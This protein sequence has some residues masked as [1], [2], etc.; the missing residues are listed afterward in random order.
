MR[1]VEQEVVLLGIGP[2]DEVY[3]SV[4]GAARDSGRELP[5]LRPGARRRGPVPGRLRGP[6]GERYSPQDVAEI[7]IAH[8]GLADERPGSWEGAN[9]LR[10][11]EGHGIVDTLADD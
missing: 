6:F 7:L 10:V 4:C 3:R 8:L 1:V 5:R 2:H 11:L 9:M